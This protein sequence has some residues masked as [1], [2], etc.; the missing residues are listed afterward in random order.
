MVD[1]TDAWRVQFRRRVLT[2]CVSGLLL[3]FLSVPL[4][5]VLYG[6]AAAISGLVVIGTLSIL[7]IPIYVLLKKLGALPTG[8]RNRIVVGWLILAA[9]VATAQDVKAAKPTEDWAFI[10]NDDL[11]VG[12]LRSHGGAIAHLS[13][14]TADF[15]VL[16]HYDHGRLV[17]QSYYGDEDGSV[18]G[19][20]PWRYNP[21][22]G[23]DY[24]GTAATV[25]EFQ[26]TDTSAHVKT[27]PRHWASGKQ[28]E[29]CSMEQWVELDGA[30]L[31]V[32]YRFTYGGETFHKSH[33]QETPAVF[34]TPQLSTL[35]TYAGAQPWT[36][37]PLT[38]RA[39]G[40]PNEYIAMTEN[41]AAYVGED[42]MGVG[43]YVRGVAEATCYRFQGGAGADCSYLAPL[44]TF[45]LKPGR[46]FSYTAYFTL[47]DA[48]TIRS[49]FAT[50]HRAGQD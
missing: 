47:G 10:Q 6:G 40:W 13:S 1:S 43:V 17:Q 19:D 9:F 31:Q 23:G 25:V 34:V 27:I 49:R 42:G 16:N 20:K 15:N 14:A 35:V 4:L 30:M 7:Q 44:H 5:G 11:R 24:H 45:A 41:W 2:V 39:P 48:K 3:S 12:L 38:R 33:H 22:Q 8:D 28:L 21:V 36:E 26:V 32:R 37:A 46:T 50:L 18:W 29:E